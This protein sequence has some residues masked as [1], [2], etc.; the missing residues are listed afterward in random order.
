MNRNA[1]T[2]ADRKRAV[3]LTLNEALVHEA[4]ALTGNLSATVDAL[5]AEYVAR[6]R[7]AR[8]E[9]QQVADAVCSDWNAVLEAG[10]GSYAD[11]HLTL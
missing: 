6:E 3:N 7:A 8:Q 10:G 2:L 5:L 1:P 11:A 9:R 4:R